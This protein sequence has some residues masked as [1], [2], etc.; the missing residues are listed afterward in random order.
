M[1]ARR[2]R[3]TLV[4]FSP[5]ALVTEAGPIAPHTIGLRLSRQIGGG[6][7][8]D[9]DLINY[10]R[11][12]VRFNLEILVRS[13]F[14]D[15]F[16]VKSGHFVRRGHIA[17]KWSEERECLTTAYHNQS[18]SRE[19]II[20]ARNNGSPAVYAN[21]RLTFDIELEPGAQ[22]HS[23]LTYDLSDGEQVFPAP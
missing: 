12:T 11:S 21:G 17:T 22:W 23:C 20:T 7:H 16:E 1:A 19:V 18:F 2:L 8:E 6:V 14:A 5:T 13:D 4:S 10:G 15:I 9:L 3:S